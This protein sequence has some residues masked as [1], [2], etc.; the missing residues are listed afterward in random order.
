M[1]VSAFRVENARP[2]G[3]MRLEFTPHGASFAFTIGLSLGA[4]HYSI[5]GSPVGEV[6]MFPGEGKTDGNLALR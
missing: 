3:A 6:R 5:A 4:E 2:Q 1:A